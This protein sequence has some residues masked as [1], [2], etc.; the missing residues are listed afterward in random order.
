[1]HK[2]HAGISY[3]LSASFSDVFLSV[4]SLRLP[5]ISAQGTLKS[6]AGNFLR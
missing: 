1:M 3:S 2:Y 5:K 4:D 6:P